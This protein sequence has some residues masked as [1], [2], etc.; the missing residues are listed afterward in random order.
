MARCRIR[1]GA[2]SALVLVFFYIT[3][4][5]V[6]SADNRSFL[7]FRV[8]GDYSVPIL[9]DELVFDPGYQASASVEYVWT[10][11]LSPFA[12]V[13]TSSLS[14]KN[15]SPISALEGSFG[16]SS[17]IDFA[18]RFFT[19][20]EASGGLFRATWGERSSNGLVANARAEIGIRLSPSFRLAADFGISR[21][22]QGAGALYTGASAGLNLS[23]FP[24][25]FDS[26]Y[27]K[28]RIDSMDLFPVFPVFYSYYDD[29]PFGYLQLA[30]NEDVLIRDVRVSFFSP[31]YMSKPTECAVFDTIDKG[32]KIRVPITALFNER[33]LSLTERTKTRGEL[34][35][36]YRMLGSK[37]E[38][39]HEVDLTVYHR[40]SMTW[41]DDRRAAAFVSAKDPAVLWFS[42]FVNAVVRDR[43]RVGID[44]NLQQA[45][46]IFEAMKLFGLAYVVDPTSAYAENA[47]NE[48]VVDYLQYPYQT[49]F[50]RGGDC[51]DLSILFSSLLQS[52]GIETAFITIPGHI[53]MAFSTEL[54]EAAARR[55]F[56]D[57]DLLIFKNG[58]AWIPVEITMV[59]D[60][61]VKA[62]RVGAKEWT[63]N[64][65]IEKANF[66]PMSENW[67]EYPPVGISDVNPR[68][69]LPDEALTMKAFDLAL[70]RHVAREIEPRIKDLKVRMGVNPTPE[71]ENSIGL[72][73]AKNGML[74]E[75]WNYF[76]AAAKKG[77][78]PA[79]TNLANVAFIRKDF[80]LARDY[81]QYSFER[82]EYD[83]AAALGIARSEYE[84]ERFTEAEAS[85]AEVKLLDEKLAGR[86]SYL[87][88]MFGGSGRSWSLSE[89]ASS[90]EWADQVRTRPIAPAPVRIAEPKVELPIPVAVAAVTATPEKAP[91][92]AAPDVPKVPVVE[93]PSAPVAPGE[94]PITPVE[95]PITPVEVVVTPEKAPA[96]E[97]IIPPAAETVSAPA[98]EPITPPVAE[99][100]SAP[101]VAAAAPVDA[102]IKEREMENARVKQAETTVETVEAKPSFVAAAPKVP[103]ETRKPI[104]KSDVPKIAPRIESAAPVD[105]DIKEREIENARVKQ[106]EAPVELPAVFPA[107]AAAAPKAPVETREP[108]V[109]SDAP[110]IASR[111]ESAAPVDV[112]IKEKEVESTRA[113]LVET[114]VEPP[115]V[116]PVV[117]AAAPIIVQPAQSEKVVEPQIA[118]VLPTPEKKPVEAVPAEIKPAPARSAA[119]RDPFPEIVP[120]VEPETPK[121]QDFVAASP[122][123]PLPEK[124]PE[125]IV[126]VPVATVPQPVITPPQAIATAKSLLDG[127]NGFKV[128]PG[129]WKLSGKKAV[130]SD[131][132]QMFAKIMT[133]TPKGEGVLRLSFDAKAT[134]YMWTGFGVHFLADRVRTLKG[135]G[136]G[137]SY[138][139]WFTSDAGVYPDASERVQVY[140]SFNDSDMRMLIDSPLNVSIR[141]SHSFVVESDPIN[142]EIRVLIDGNE[143]LRAPMGNVVLDGP[144]IIIRALD[145]AEFSDFR[146]ESIQ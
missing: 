110:T 59:K 4:Q 64:A 72:A 44:R 42:R 94:V 61:F 69:Q 143:C 30:N 90:V 14:L 52:V 80:K 25:G 55:D 48:D 16:L 135:Y 26:D 33:I 107:L 39:R 21:F 95:A 123:V 127:F 22:F 9:G 78:L 77:Y 136:A 17:R 122:Q 18:E 84:L 73:Y 139:V 51:D 57:P 100:I 43:F 65:R 111:I 66:Y 141:D 74:T 5:E 132:L 105:A 89:R 7:R 92:I 118:E 144:F 98:A 134:G 86:Y 62:W 130:Q 24:E 101:V 82:A 15:L 126:S 27:S 38:Y 58:K 131:P 115:T 103:V 121:A 129:S 145:T 137:A 2:V 76:S 20:A 71:T 113:K 56:Y 138:L 146:V 81:Y 79:W 83:P 75:A 63:D 28:I 87:A 106:A 91:V 125:V 10:P 37:R 128:G 97:P 119:V 47:N 104:A 6:V 34:I 140:R 116:K 3:I 36:Q 49:L 109:K 54:T 23:V 1:I 13:A 11:L 29:H 35:V 70:D 31:E 102:D 99:T 12:R 142:K 41:S 67:K 50:Y 93:T 120:S 96:A 8:G 32:S 85:Y 60:G 45:V 133:K 46:G 68:F 19:R 112:D 88:S 114:P 117:A 124:K 53:Y 40:N 108:I